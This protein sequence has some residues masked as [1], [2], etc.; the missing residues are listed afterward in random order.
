M[1][2]IPHL[3]KTVAGA[4]VLNVIGVNIIGFAMRGVAEV[5]RN[6]G[7]LQAIKNDETLDEIVRTVIVREALRMLIV[8]RAL[9]M[10]YITVQ[11]GFVYLLYRKW[12][13]LMAVAGVLVMAARLPD[14]IHQ[15]ETNSRDLKNRS[16][17]KNFVTMI[18]YLL[19]VPTLIW[20]STD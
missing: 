6:K 20:F 17:G 16:S 10:F 12:G 13:V 15:I 9:S 4:F 2:V 14:L 5:V 18:F 11:A 1:D 7:N 3:I 19:I 8:A